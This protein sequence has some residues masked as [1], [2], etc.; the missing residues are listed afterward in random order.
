ME[1]DWLIWVYLKTQQD[2]MIAEKNVF[3]RMLPALDYL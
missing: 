1:I 3:N 2:A